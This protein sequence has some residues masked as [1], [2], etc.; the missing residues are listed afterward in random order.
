MRISRASL[1]LLP[2]LGLLAAFFLLPSLDVIQASIMDPDFTTRHFE[3]IVDRSVYLRVFWRTLEVSLVVALLAALVGYPVAY[4]ITLQPRRLQFLLIFLIF[5]PLWMS[6]LI[7]SYAWM[8]VLGR[9]G[10][11]NSALLGLGLVDKPARLLF[12]TGAVYVAML[13]IL[14]PVQIVTCYAAMSEVDRDLVRTARVLGAKP[15]QAFR[16]VFLPLTLDG[17]I[18]G[19]VIVFMLS[20]GFFITPA[21]VGGRGDLMLANLIEGQVQQLNWGFAAALGILLLAGT[22]IAVFIIRWLGRLA[23]RVVV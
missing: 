4:F 18:T 9:D 21:L 17:T 14:L 1:L 15:L 20:M 16:R 6:I 11:V 7:R 19:A 10:I 5:I 3:R 23:L 2:A 22:V 13:Q 12:T 8:V